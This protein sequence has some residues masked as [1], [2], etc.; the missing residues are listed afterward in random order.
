LDKYKQ[1]LRLGYIF[2]NIIL[3]NIDTT[4]YSNYYFEK[5]MLTKVNLCKKKLTFPENS[6]KNKGATAGILIESRFFLTAV[7]IISLFT[8]L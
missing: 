1:T 3:K 4:F 5:L 7:K 6:K 2:R 8:N